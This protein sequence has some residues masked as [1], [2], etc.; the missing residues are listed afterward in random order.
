MKKLAILLLLIPSLVFAGSD[1]TGIPAKKWFLGIG[2]SPIFTGIRFNFIDRDIEKVNGLSFTMWQPKSDNGGG[3][4]NGISMGVPMAGG[5]GKRNGLNFGIL[6]VSANQSLN[7]IN[8][9][10]VGAGA[11]E[12][13][14]GLNIGGI[15][16]G[17]GG[18]L[19]GINL[20]G[21]GLGS[22]GDVTGFNFAAIG[23]ASGGD[24]KGINLSGIGDG[25][26]ED[27]T[28]FS[29]G[30]VGVGA[31]GD[32]KGINIAGVG[33]G[34]GGD[35]KGINV[36]GVGVGSGGT[37]SGINV[38]LV[39]LGAPE[40]KGL[41]VAT[42]VGGNQIK[43]I[44]VAPGLVQVGDKERSSEDE[45]VHKGVAIAAVTN[46][47]GDNNGVC[48]GLLNMTDG[49]KGFQLGLININRS[50]PKGLRW[51]PIFNASFGK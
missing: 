14:N 22:G 3:S 4:V 11:G 40:V 31:G 1:G 17:S 30:L 39:G 48:I 15:G 45:I 24:L 18:E 26:G 44:S 20:A 29:F 10:G 19:N 38:A 43:G 9:G 36:G 25:A 12:N 49:G 28:G 8:I 23:V 6:G 42:V 7:G 2:N 37:L 5:A 13:V 46:I 41:S 33:M 27:I 47:R 51:L 16:L 32:M 21:I 50:N 35:V 34:A